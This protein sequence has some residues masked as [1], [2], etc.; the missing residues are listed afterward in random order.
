M[1]VELFF[2]FFSFKGQKMY[3]VICLF[4]RVSTLDHV[5]KGKGERRKGNGK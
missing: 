3:V 2:F 4:L 1:L 5:E